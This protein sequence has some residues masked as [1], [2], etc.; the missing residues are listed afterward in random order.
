VPVATG[1]GRAA[2]RN[3]NAFPLNA[4]VGNLHRARDGR[5]VS[6]SAANAAVTRRLLR[7]VGGDALAD[8]PRWASAEARTAGMDALYAVFDAWMAGRTADQALATAIEH[9]VVL[10]A[11]YG[12]DALLADPHVA[13]RGDLEADVAPDGRRRVAPA[14]AIRVER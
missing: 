3:G 13:A 12:V 10:G 6:V 8:D 9:D 1:T 11:V 7:M 4:G 5:Y 2:A 14:P